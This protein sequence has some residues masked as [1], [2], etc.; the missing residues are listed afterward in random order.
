MEQFNRTISLIGEES[1]NKIKTSKIAVYG[2]GGVGGHAIMALARCGVGT[3][4][5]YDKD[6]VDITNINRQEVADLSTIGQDKVEVIAKKIKKINKDCEVIPKKVELSRDNLDDNLPK[7][8]D[9][10]LDCIDNINCKAF[11]A[12]LCYN[13][14]IHILSCMGAGN[15][16]TANFKVMDIN[17]TSYDPLAK[18]MRRLLK[19]DNV[20]KL[21]VLCD[22]S[23]AVKTGVVAPS[24]VGFVTAAAGLKMAEYVVNNIIKSKEE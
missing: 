13:N 18:V 10:V 4:Y 8:I 14:N 12:K 22:C 21:N 23:Q 7:D 19:E 11:L 15:R 16:L 20:P 2:V 5:V 6:I 3:I 17:K 24:S 1:F 9:F